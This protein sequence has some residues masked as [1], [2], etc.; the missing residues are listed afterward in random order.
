MGFGH[1]HIEGFSFI[2]GFDHHQ[3]KTLFSHVALEGYFFRR[4][5]YHFGVIWGSFW[6]HLGFILV[7]S[8][9]HFG[10]IWGS[11][12]NNEDIFLPILNTFFIIPIEFLLKTHV[13]IAEGKRCKI[14]HYLLNLS[15]PTLRNHFVS[16]YEKK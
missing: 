4:H 1:H 11:L 6:G 15:K 5:R 7:S 10:V 2:Y 13:K 14:R 9:G 12:K 3:L 8:G 16:F